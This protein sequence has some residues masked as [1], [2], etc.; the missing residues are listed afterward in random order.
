[1]SKKTFFAGEKEEK[2]KKRNREEV[3]KKRELQ[4]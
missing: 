2:I 3:R 1:M 4:R